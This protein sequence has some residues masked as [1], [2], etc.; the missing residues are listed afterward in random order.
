MC[1]PVL[2]EREEIKPLKSEEPDAQKLM[3][4]IE[5]IL[6]TV[7]LNKQYR[8]R[9][10]PVIRDGSAKANWEV[11]VKLPSIRPWSRAVLAEG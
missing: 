1:L 8:D 3:K 6:K 2:E 5:A 9:D 4:E 7:H 11:E 10:T